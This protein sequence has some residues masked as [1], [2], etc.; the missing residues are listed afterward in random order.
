[1]ADS[2]DSP[3]HL[4][5]QDVSELAKLIRGLRDELR[6]GQVMTMTTVVM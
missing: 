1:M 4:C 3:K 2:T 5:G 6:S